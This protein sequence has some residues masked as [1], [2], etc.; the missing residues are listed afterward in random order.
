M[1]PKIIFAD[2][3]NLLDDIRKQFNALG[4]I[5]QLTLD[6]KE[7]LMQEVSDTELVIAEYARI[8]EHLLERG[9]KL[10]GILV[11]GTGT[12]HVDLEAAESKGI[13]VANTRGAN[14]GAVAELTFSLMLN[15]IRRTVNAH[16][17]IRG[18]KWKSGD[19]GELPEEFTGTE[20]RNKRLGIIGFGAIGRRV[21][22]IGKGFG[23][24]VSFYD[25]ILPGDLS[26]ELTARSCN[27]LDA[28]LQEADIVSVHAPLT[29]ATCNMLN[30]EK[31]HL[32]KLSSILIVTSRGGIVDEEV[33]AD[34]L[35]RRKI[36]AAGLDVFRNEPL[37]KASKLLS[38]DNVVL[39]PHIG[40]STRESVANISR[41]LFEQAIA[42][43]NGKTPINLVTTK[44]V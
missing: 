38:L 44:I 28:L 7:T 39:T 24:E 5:I 32:L 4:N 1:K 37:D 10:K 41:S 9:R 6:Q 8:D 40:G 23:L 29:P 15:C 19:S 3:F 16:R 21:A 43:L 26:P 2:S 18:E 31:L 30:A 14:A 13:P 11:Y 36:A 33:L 17:Y 42:I 35:E 12:N 34:M 25:P 20:L 27:S 22:E